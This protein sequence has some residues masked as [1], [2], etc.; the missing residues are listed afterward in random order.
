MQ[1]FPVSDIRRLSFV[2]LDAFGLTDW[3]GP[4][5]D[6]LPERIRVFSGPEA[7]AHARKLGVHGLATGNS[8]LIVGG[9]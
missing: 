1:T 8:I 9:G 5:R 7:E 6:Q 4:L 2:G 3:A